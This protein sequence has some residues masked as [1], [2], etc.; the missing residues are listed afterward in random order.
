MSELGNVFRILKIENNEGYLIF[1]LD[2]RI[3]SPKHRRNEPPKSG[4]VHTSRN[5]I[6]M[7][8]VMTRMGMK[9]T[10]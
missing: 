2:I 7:I 9:F 5:I 3:R 1:L 4:A 8:L 6:M 10:C